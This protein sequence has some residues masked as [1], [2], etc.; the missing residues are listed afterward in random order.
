MHDGADHGED[1][2]IGDNEPGPRIVVEIDVVGL[3][4]GLG[5]PARAA[6]ARHKYGRRGTS[7]IAR[8]AQQDRGG[9]G[10]TGCVGGR[11][12]AV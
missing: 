1:E 2:R 10:D 6:H 4:V 9:G 3:P 8:E 5:Q 7:C 11:D 12:G